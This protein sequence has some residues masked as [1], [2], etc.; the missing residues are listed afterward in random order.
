MEHVL[1]DF[2]GNYVDN[3][4]ALVIIESLQKEIDMFRKYSDYYG[5]IFFILENK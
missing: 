4:D 2:R 1:N 5:Y 3:P